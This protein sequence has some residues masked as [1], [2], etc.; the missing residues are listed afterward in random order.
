MLKNYF[1]LKEAARYLDS[2]LHGFCIKEV[3]TQEKNKFV[4]SFYENGNSELKY[5][6]FSCDSTLHY[7]IL[8]QNFSKAKKNTVILFDEIYDLKIECIGLFKDDRIINF[9]LSNSINIYF[10]FFTGKINFFICENDVIINAFKNRN[11]Y[12]DKS[13]SDL[14]KSKSIKSGEINKTETIKDFYKS[15]Y[16]KFGYLFFE[17]LLHILNLNEKDALDDHNKKLIEEEFDKF[18]ESLKTPEY[19]FYEKE[20]KSEISLMKFNHLQTYN[21]RSFT[22]INELLSEYIKNFYKVETRKTVKDSR[23]INLQD[24]IDVVDKKIMGLMKQIKVSKQSEQNFIYGEHILSNLQ[25]IKKGDKALHVNDETTGDVVII[26]LD[27]SL[28]P[29]DNAQKYFKKYKGQK[30]SLKVLKDK[31]NIFKKE[32][33]KLSNELK[34]LSEIQDY[35]TLSKMNKKQ[36]IKEKED[37]ETSKFRKFILSDDFEVWVG[38][39]SKSNDLLTTKFSSPNDLW[40]HVRGTSGSHTVL[41]ISNKKKNI[42]KQIIQTTASIAAYYSKARNASNVPVA[43]CERKHVKKK[44]G[45]KQGSVV[46]VREKVIFVKPALPESTVR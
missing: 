33:E 9:N 11:L 18:S 26:K 32:K 20:S 12:I 42:D 8:K 29:S 21:V 35:K 5:L 2:A 23:L 43:Y 28:S 40:F 37:K 39:D 46:M 25:N 16:L 41:K 34:R 45:F 10:F 4:M 7:L 1:V 38:K 6:E 3:F 19:I 13:I 27:E 17:E 15:N 36:D 31:V 14:F 30:D 24:K 22:N 44:K